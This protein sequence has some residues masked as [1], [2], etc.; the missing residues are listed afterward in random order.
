MSVNIRTIGG[1]IGTA[2]V[3]SIVT[4]S[5]DARGLPLESAYTTAFI[6]LAGF[7]VAAFVASFLV[8]SIRR[9]RAMAEPAPESVSD[10]RVPAEVG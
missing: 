3:S 8:P 7:S 10:L 5:T 1:A 9:T 4:S 6:V 2:V